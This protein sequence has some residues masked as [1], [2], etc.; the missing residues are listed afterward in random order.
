MKNIIRNFSSLARNLLNAY[1]ICICCKHSFDLQVIWI[2]ILNMRGMAILHPKPECFA[3]QVR[4][5]TRVILGNDIKLTIFNAICDIILKCAEVI[6]FQ[7]KYDIII[8]INES[9]FSI[10]ADNRNAVTCSIGIVIF[11]RND[12]IIV[13]INISVFSVFFNICQPAAKW[14]SNLILT[15]NHFFSSRIDIADKIGLIRD[16]PRI[17]TEKRACSIKWF[18]SF[19]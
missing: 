2:C 10:V 8:I 7:W 4:I 1:D 3:C 12:D 13:Y 16:D 9:V 6:P 17:T 11:K 5:R 15:R 14:I 19:V 18:I